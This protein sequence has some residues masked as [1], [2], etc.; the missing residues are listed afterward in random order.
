MNDGRVTS[1][2]TSAKHEL[3][4]GWKPRVLSALNALDGRSVVFAKATQSAL[5]DAVLP[6]SGGRSG[7]VHAGSTI[8]FHVSEARVQRRL[9]SGALRVVEHSVRSING[10]NQSRGGQ[11]W[12]EPEHREGSKFIIG[13]CSKSHATCK[14]KLLKNSRV[15]RLIRALFDQHQLGLA[16][17]AGLNFPRIGNSKRTSSKLHDRKA[18]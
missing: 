2:G 3:I 10:K 14:K 8:G 4:E 18:Q 7:E 12:P 15:R 16:V 13:V 1:N 5:D 17:I 11:G 6:A 9:K